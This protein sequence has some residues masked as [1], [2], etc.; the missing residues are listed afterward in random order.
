MAPS[1]TAVLIVEDDPGTERLERRLLEDDGYTVQSVA[2][3]E[4]AIALVSDSEPDLIL[5]DICL[6]GIDGFTTCSVLRKFSQARIIMVT[7]RDATADKVKGID[8][9]ADDYIAKP[10]ADDELLVRA[11]AVMRRPT[12]SRTD[13]PRTSHAKNGG[14][15]FGTAWLKFAEKISR[16]RN[17]ERRTNLGAGLAKSNLSGQRLVRNLRRNGVK[18][19]IDDRRSYGRYTTGEPRSEGQNDLRLTWSQRRAFANSMGLKAASAIWTCCCVPALWAYGCL[20]MLLRGA[21][22]NPGMRR[23]FAAVA[24]FGNDELEVTF[25]KY[26]IKIVNPR[27]NPPAAEPAPLEDVSNLAATQDESALGELGLSA[28]TSPLDVM[29]TSPS[30]ISTRLAADPY[31]L[32]LLDAMLK[33]YLNQA[34]A[35][36]ED[37]MLAVPVI[38]IVDIF[39]QVAGILGKD[40]SY[41]RQ[42]FA[43]DIYRLQVSGLDTTLTGAKVQLPISRGVPG[44][45]LTVL[46]E[47]GREVRYFGIR[48]IQTEKPK[49]EIPPDDSEGEFRS[50]E[51]LESPLY[52]VE[53]RDFLGRLL[54][55]PSLEFAEF[56]ANQIKLKNLSGTELRQFAQI[57][58][59]AMHRDVGEPGDGLSRHDSR[60]VAN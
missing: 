58:R 23:F 57:A 50:F 5:L 9:G 34:S 25:G 36:C 17:S 54:E 60:D 44:K 41:T 6:P 30:S 42:D 12:S 28:E 32:N 13:K 48:F 4:E 3:G 38:P 2:S 56:L 52:E 14:L 39:S 46:D 51:S 53:L 26:G 20:R 37:P 55:W 8:I 59:D 21:R 19:L 22:S 11:K 31:H 29:A 43:E 33:S 10:F 16:I 49:A 47:S 40:D 27:G 7:G 15:R 35:K 45:T 1:N 24:R 18:G